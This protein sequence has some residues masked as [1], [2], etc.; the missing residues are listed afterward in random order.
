M[1]AIKFCQVNIVTF[2]QDII[3]L[4]EKMWKKQKYTLSKK[5]IPIQVDHT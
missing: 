1:Y 3:Q 4:Q 5:Y 2:F